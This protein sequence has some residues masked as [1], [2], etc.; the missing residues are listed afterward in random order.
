MESTDKCFMFPQ[1]SYFGSAENMNSAFW[2]GVKE[3]QMELRR[4]PVW[5]LKS[6]K[7]ELFSS[8]NARPG[9]MTPASEMCCH[10]LK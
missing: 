9:L 6:G 8:V 2:V 4:T 10:N 3:T 1:L 7:K 5:S